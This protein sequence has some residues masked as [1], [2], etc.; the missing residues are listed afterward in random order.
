VRRLVVLAVTAAGAL[1]LAACSETSVMVTVSLAAG[2]AA[3]TTLR[4][5]LFDE[6]GLLPKT[7]TFPLGNTSLPGTVSLRHLPASVH[8]LR[9]L[10]DGL[11]GGGAV[12]AQAAGSLA[13][14]AGLKNEARL[15]LTRG[16]LPDADGD[17]VPDAID[18]CPHVAN[19]DQASA[20]GVVGDACRADGGVGDANLFADPGFEQGLD[21]WSTSYAT[22][23]RVADPHGGAW[24][25]RLCVAN[26]GAP[27]FTADF[28]PLLMPPAPGTSYRA[29][30][31]VKSLDP[32]RVSADIYLREKNQGSSLNHVLTS[33]TSA[34]GQWTE[35]FA[36]PLLTATD[37][38]VGDELDLVVELFVMGGAQV[39]DCIE[40]DDVY[41][42][43]SP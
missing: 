29:S 32:A 2:A 7:T 39:G 27:F 12:A 8:Q 41:V 3:P 24:S 10:F 38:G 4:A 26:P 33:A 15:A 21:G 18:N 40:V 42:A 43:P 36:G 31:W 30:A 16:R 22:L 23:T 35:L 1:A 28:F 9:L 5:T 6:H 17:Q 37:G 14:T 11:D 34:S 20:D 25:A 13:L 19:P